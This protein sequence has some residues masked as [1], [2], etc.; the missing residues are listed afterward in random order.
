MVIADKFVL[1]AALIP[2]RGGTSVGAPANHVRAKSYVIADSGHSW[3]H[4]LRPMPGRERAK[5]YFFRRQNLLP[6]NTPP[7]AS[8]L[9]MPAPIRGAG[10]PTWWC[11]GG[12]PPP[13]QPMIGR[14]MSGPAR[15]GVTKFRTNQAL[16]ITNLSIG[17][18]ARN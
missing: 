14:Q 12:L 8:A 17:D 18:S 10:A 13:I 9:G 11:P 3:E 1:G 15:A 2:R 4:S 7:T 16:T 6:S 5:S